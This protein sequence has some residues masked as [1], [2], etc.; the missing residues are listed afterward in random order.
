MRQSTTRSLL[1]CLALTGAAGH[2][3]ASELRH[4]APEPVQPAEPATPPVDRLDE[5][6]MDGAAAAAR[7]QRAAT[8]PKAQTPAP[9]RTAGDSR[10]LPSR[11]HSFL[12]GMFR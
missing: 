9:A 4:L 1:V 11:F 10:A 5:V 7:A 2:A 8:K 6:D 12:P 3:G